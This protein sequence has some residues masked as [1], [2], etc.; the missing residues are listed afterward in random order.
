MQTGWD[1]N[2][3]CGIVGSHNYSGRTNNAIL[4]TMR[5]TLS[6]RGPDDAGNYFDRINCVGLGHRRPSVID[7]SPHCHQPMSNYDQ[8]IW[9]TYNGEIYNYKELREELVKLGYSF[10]SNSDTEVLLYAY[11]E[12]GIKCIEKFIGMFAIAIWDSNKHELFY[13]E[14]GPGK[15]V[16]LLL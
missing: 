3:L 14:I 5:D 12:W 6:H 2:K 16:I 4:T 1:T 9:I 8:S 11:Q 7:L 13:V 15:T 10:R